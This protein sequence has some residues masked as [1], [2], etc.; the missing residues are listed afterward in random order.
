MNDNS[1]IV[2][3]GINEKGEYAFDPMPREELVRIAKGFPLNEDDSHDISAIHEMKTSPHFG[4][5][6]DVQK[7]ITQ[8]GWGLIIAPDMPDFQAIMDALNPLLKHR[9]QQVASVLFKKFSYL[10][11]R[12]RSPRDF[13]A[14]HGVSFGT[15]NPKKVPYYLLIVGSPTDI[16]MEFQ[17]L[18]DVQ[19]AVGRIHFDKIEEYASYVQGVVAREQTSLPLDK[20]L[21]FFSVKNIGD[22]PTRLSSKDFVAPLSD[23]L[24]E[25]YTKYNTA[26][27]VEVIES[28]ANKERLKAFLEETTL[29]A[30]LMTTSHGMVIDYDHPKQKDI[31]GALVCNT[32]QPGRQITNKD[33]FAAVDVMPSVNLKGMF[34]L[35]FACF[36]GGTPQHDSLK[37]QHDPD[38]NILTTKDFISTLPKKLLLAGASAIIAHFDRALVFSFMGIRKSDNTVTFQGVIELLLS[39]YPIGHAASHLNDYY[40]AAESELSSKQYS[41]RKDSLF[42]I[43]DDEIES[44]FMQRTD[45]KGYFLLGDPASRLILTN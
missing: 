40:A 17:F 35:M 4:V 19:Y 38:E 15:V 26:W 9:E 7:E 14:D 42:T 22:D 13:L 5:L 16:P 41:L 29:P 20:R 23:A 3:N 24:R 37:Y 8:Q 21:S 31:Q 43:K 28:D 1:L 45:A 30:F 6:G 39:G 33:Y 27:Q 18:L 44:I 36:S 32:W 2:F 34:I 25:T 11:E 10:R 12:H